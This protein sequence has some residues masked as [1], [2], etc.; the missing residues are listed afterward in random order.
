MELLFTKTEEG[1][2][3]EFSA[4]GPFNLHIERSGKGFIKLYQR[5]CPEGLYQKTFS[6]GG[7]NGGKVFDCDFGAL[8]Y[9]KW[10]KVVSSKPVLKAE[11]TTE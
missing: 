1:F 6:V 3:A 5:G 2:V 11:V 7:D 4:D 10:I 9:P 8:V